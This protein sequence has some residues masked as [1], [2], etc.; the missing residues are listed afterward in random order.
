MRTGTLLIAVVLLG[1]CQGL[2]PPP[3]P[4]LESHFGTF[5]VGIFKG[6]Q[7]NP[8][9]E[10]MCVL[11]MQGISE[12]AGDLMRYIL[13]IFNNYVYIFQSLNE[14]ANFMDSFDQAVKSCEFS[15]LLEQ[16]TDL[17]NNGGRAAIVA[18]VAIKSSAVIDS[19]KTFYYGLTN[20]LYE[21]AGM[22]MGQ[23]L[24]IILNFNI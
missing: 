17:R 12:N 18:R 10:S 4:K 23:I 16:V 22:G 13:N 11:E 14:F 24:S 5:L 3:A 20:S 1:L 21:S 6:F 9:L 8:N 15:R 2:A 19:W 7:S